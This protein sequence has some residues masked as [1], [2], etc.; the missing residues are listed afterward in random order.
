MRGNASEICDLKAVTADHSANRPQ[1]LMRHR[2]QLVENSEFVHHFQ[3]GRMDRVSTEIAKEILMLFQDRDAY[4]SAREQI[5][6]HD[7]R[8]TAT[9]NAT[10]CLEAVCHSDVSLAF[11]L[12]VGKREEREF[13]KWPTPLATE[14]SSLATALRSHRAIV[15]LSGPRKDVVNAGFL[16]R[17][18]RELQRR[19][20][21]DGRSGQGFKAKKGSRKKT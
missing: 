16:L 3:C 8:R 1:F 4:P 13:D 6:K 20:G 17:R 2:Q 9:H 12:L 11:I 7:A 19:R 5:R 15:G 14:T 10:R 18:V 21:Q